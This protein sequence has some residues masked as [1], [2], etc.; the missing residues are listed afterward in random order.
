MANGK[1]EVMFVLPARARV[2]ARSQ[3]VFT[4][5]VDTEF[6]WFSGANDAEPVEFRTELVAA[7]NATVYRPIYGGADTYHELD[8]GVYTIAFNSKSGAA[9]TQVL[10]LELDTQ[11]IPPTD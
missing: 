9:D 4:V 10:R 11:F 8:P 3:P 5:G 7:G 6:T 1:G 2:R